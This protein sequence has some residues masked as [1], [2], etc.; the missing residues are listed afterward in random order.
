MKK[1]VLPSPMVYTL[2]VEKLG[3]ETDWPNL[4]RM[5]KLTCTLLKPLVCKAN[6]FNDIGSSRRSSS[7]IETSTKSFRI[8]QLTPSAVGDL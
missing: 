8:E 2:W 5:Q 7:L 4:Y 6:E 3:L 1:H